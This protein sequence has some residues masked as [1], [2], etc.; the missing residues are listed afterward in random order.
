LTTQK[1][2]TFSAYKCRC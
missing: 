2:L 1:A